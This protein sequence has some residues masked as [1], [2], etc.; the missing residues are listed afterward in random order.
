MAYAVLDALA[1]GPRDALAMMR[2]IPGR[3]FR[4]PMVS[5]A[6]QVSAH[7]ENPVCYR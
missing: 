1:R 7:S 2:T 5:Q 4:H 3:L 6:L